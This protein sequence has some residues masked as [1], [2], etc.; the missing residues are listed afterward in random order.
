MVKALR[1]IVPVIA[2]ILVL[3]L[4][5][6]IASADGPGWKTV[7]QDFHGLL[8]GLNAGQND[9]LLVADSGAG[10]TKLDPDSGETSLLASLPNVTDVIQVGRGEYMALTGGGDPAGPTDARLWRIKDGDVTEVAD[11]GK[12][13]A[14]HD[15]D[16]AG[17]DSNPYHLAKLSR[18]KILVADA[19]GNDILIVDKNGDIDVVAV[20]PKHEVPTQ[21][22]KDAA[23]CPAGPPD[24]CGLPDTFAADAVATS[25]AV[26]PD[27]AI[28]AGELTGFPATPG[29][30]RVWRIE[31]DAR[32]VT[33]GSDDDGCTLVDSPAFT[34]IV[35]ITFGKDGTAYVVELD[36]ASW[37]AAT[38]GGGGV[39]GTVNACKIHHGGGDDD[40]NRR[41]DN[42]D[43]ELAC[44]EV[45]TGLPF[46]LA[47][48]VAD[49]SVYVTLA[50]GPEGPVEVA[51]LTNGDEG[52]N[53]GEDNSNGDHDNNGNGD[54]EGRGNGDNNGH[55]NSD[56]EGGGGGND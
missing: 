12:F 33:C 44:K 42:G 3:G 11:L 53:G 15:P 54:N 7:S 9:Q 40:G 10:P 47:A 5:A 45:G 32:H 48:A 19:G 1:R 30:S 18:N 25:V 55:G 37:L 46:P 13:E 20:L 21:P 43:V 36:E 4:T 22:V 2:A 24:I 38:E 31:P 27:G 6:S 56:H 41:H 23:G 16:G 8:F 35:D 49:H 39:G 52:D 29:F 14:D 26:G 51:V 28:Y 50:L 34:S 17:V